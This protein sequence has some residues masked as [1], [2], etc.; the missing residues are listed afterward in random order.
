MSPGRWE[1]LLRAAFEHEAEQSAARHPQERGD[2]PPLSRMARAVAE[3]WTPAE[4]EHLP[5]CAR[6]QKVLTAEWRA[7][8]PAPW[9][10]LRHL[11]G[12][13]PYARSLDAHLDADECPRCRRLMGS[14]V[15]RALAEGWYWSAEAVSGPVMLAGWVGRACRR[16]PGNSRPPHGR[17][18][19]FISVTR[20]AA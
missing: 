11:A 3:S 18:F 8:C 13:S 19:S 20:R 17:R 6:C 9:E 10:L 4:L 5:H 15:L 14:K 7:G 12:R 1:P 2:C 16:R